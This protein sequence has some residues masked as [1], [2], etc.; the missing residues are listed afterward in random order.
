[1]VGFAAETE[2]VRENAK[3][4]FAQKQLDAI[5]LNDVSRPGIGFGSDRNAGEII[6]ATET[7]SIDEMS[8]AEMAGH[9]LDAVVKLRLRNQILKVSE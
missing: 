4:K 1:M 5:V 9:V 6:T 7:V 8:K 3:K 2:N